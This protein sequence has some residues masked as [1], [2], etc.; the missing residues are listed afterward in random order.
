MSAAGEKGDYSSPKLGSGGERI[1]VARKIDFDDG[2]DDRIS[3]ED[4]VCG[5]EGLR[6]LPE[7]P[8][9]LKENV[10]PPLLTRDVCCLLWDSQKCHVLLTLANTLMKV[11][12]ITN[13][14]K[15][16]TI[17]TAMIQMSGLRRGSDSTRG[18]R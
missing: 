11:N 1:V 9:K 6:P 5:V 10:M 7:S 4:K 2:S 17:T 18:C 16:R 13:E 15:E 12:L 14:V 8:E 3:D